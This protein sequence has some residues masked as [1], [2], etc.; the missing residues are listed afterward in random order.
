MTKEMKNQSSA[1]HSTTTLT[2]TGAKSVCPTNELIPVELIQISSQLKD[3]SLWFDNYKKQATEIEDCI[4]D[5]L[6]K[7]Q[8]FTTAIIYHI[9]EIVACEFRNNTYYKFT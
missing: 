7:I 6:R 8:D 9:G 5:D 3:I 1:K 4:D 2:P